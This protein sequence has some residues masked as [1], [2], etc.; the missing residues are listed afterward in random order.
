MKQ[1]IKR[2]AK[3]NF[4]FGRQL[5]YAMS[6]A[7]NSF[8]GERDH[9]STRRTHNYRL[10]IFARFCRKNGLVDARLI[11]QSTLDLYGE[12]LR[13]R[14]QG[15]F[16]WP[17][18]I[19]DKR[20]SIAYA[21]NLISTANTVLFAMRRNSKIELSALRVLNK[22]RS[23]VRKEPANA[24]QAAVYQAV[25]RMLIQ[26]DRRGA[27]VVL[28]ARHWGMRAQEATLQDLQRMHCEVITTGG[29]CILEGCKGGRKS[30][31]RWLSATP[32]RIES[33]EFALG[34][35][36]I[37]S[38]CLLAKTETVKTFYQRELNRCRRVL[39]SFDII[40]YRELRAAFA[41]DVYESAT[42]TQPM[43]GRNVPRELDRK[44]REEVARVLGHG[45][46]EISSCY[47]GGY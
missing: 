22:S 23:H 2:G 43:S 14:L 9:Y 42:G 24:D 16:V 6:Q 18:G 35:R 12:Y 4:G 36:P 34:T 29:A 15:D 30:K 26:G 7:V 44:A 27:A 32:E 13:D 31:D 47:V 45:R 37:G 8:Y 28:L 10:R 3:R 38:R 11:T 41:A 40:S 17:D 46:V 39:H 25:A 33:L 19:V 20:I 5:R 1:P 21:H